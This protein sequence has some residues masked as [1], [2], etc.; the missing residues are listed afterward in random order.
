M[1][2][3]G[4]LSTVGQELSLECCGVAQ[5]CDA[6]ADAD[7]S[8]LPPPRKDVLVV[9]P[10]PLQAGRPCTEHPKNLVPDALVPEGIDEGV[11]DQT[12]IC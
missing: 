7:T 5:I 4:D 3:V 6:S 9:T 1:S 10:R 12:A 11:D 2:S 8:R